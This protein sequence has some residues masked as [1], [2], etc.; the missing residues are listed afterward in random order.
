MKKITPEKAAELART[1]QEAA[2]ELERAAAVDRPTQLRDAWDAFSLSA[3]QAATLNWLDEAT[4]AAAGLTP[5][6][7]AQMRQEVDAARNRTPATAAAGFA[8]DVVGSLATAPL[9]VMRGVRGIAAGAGLGAAAGA[10][11][12]ETPGGRAAGAALGGGLGALVGAGG[13]AVSKVRDMRAAERLAA[14]FVREN[15][16]ATGTAATPGMLEKLLAKITPEPLPAGMRRK[17]AETPGEVFDPEAPLPAEP[18]EVSLQEAAEAAAQRQRSGLPASWTREPNRM[19]DQAA[20]EIDA[21]VAARAA[22]GI[23]TAPGQRLAW[24][25][26]RYDLLKSGGER[27]GAIKAPTRDIAPKK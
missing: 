22:N 8:G 6:E 14:D 24:I 20:A 16:A 2:A 7:T 15:T 18:A 13:A 21:I 9:T 23:P 19:L 5:E 3:G 25:R 4:A 26:E 10:G 1:S 27:A 12:G 17:P 11:A